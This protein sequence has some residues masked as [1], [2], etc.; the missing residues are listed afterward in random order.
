TLD[1]DYRNLWFNYL[2]IAVN[3]TLKNNI[4][5][6]I[7]GAFAQRICPDATTANLLLSET[8]REQCGVRGIA[9]V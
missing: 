4:A 1:P 3:L 9:E 5:L 7:K 2:K 8:L 6:T